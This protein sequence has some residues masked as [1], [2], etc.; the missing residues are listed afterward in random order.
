MLI[1]K[2]SATGPVAPIH[3]GT[4]AI[5]WVN[6][7]RFLGITVDNK[8]SW[9]SHML[10]LKRIFAKKLDLIRRSRF[11]PKDVL[12]N[13][14]FKI[15][16]PSVTYGLVLWGS[17]FNVDL[18]YLL[19]RL[20]CGAARIIF[21]LP[22]DMRSSDVLIQ[23]DWHPLSYCYKLVLLKLMHKA[24]HD[25]LP[26]VLSDNIVTKCPT[27]YSLRASD[28]LT[29][30]RF[31]S[32]YGKNPIAYRGPALWKIVTS[33]DKNFS[34]TSNKNLKRKMRSMESWLSK[35]PLQQPQLLDVEISIIFRGF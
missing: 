15:I 19:E 34:N 32:I 13:F 8:L 1:C 6:K 23:A 21:N 7:S 27:G 22:K 26:Q 29:V 2:T 5:E 18:F 12:I 30:H 31:N 35:R 10:D 9:V 3:I 16:L 25:E 33:K 14:Y 4:D 11:L 28:S 17:C 24:F 20:H